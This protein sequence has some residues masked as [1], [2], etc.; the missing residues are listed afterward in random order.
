MKVTIPVHPIEL[1]KLSQVDG[2]PG[3]SH[4]DFEGA[5]IQ[6]S[7]SYMD[8]SKRSASILSQIV[9]LKAKEFRTNE[10]FWWKDYIDDKGHWSPDLK[11]TDLE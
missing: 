8:I 1:F 11:T 5:H 10:S 9:N 4:T 2:Q 3:S 7:I 6:Y